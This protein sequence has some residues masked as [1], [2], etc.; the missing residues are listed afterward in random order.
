MGVG[1]EV[2]RKGKGCSRYT[3]VCARAHTARAR[4]HTECACA[5]VRGRACSHLEAIHGVERGH[6]GAKGEAQS[7]AGPVGETALENA[8]LA[9]AKG[10]ARRGETRTVRAQ[11]F[12]RR[13]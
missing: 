12:A 8:A 1:R 7:A 9:C 4:V 3:S 13:R 2:D 6:E 5:R 10:G 11:E